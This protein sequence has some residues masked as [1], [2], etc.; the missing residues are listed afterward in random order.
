MGG[1]VSVAVGSIG[2]VCWWFDRECEHDC[3]WDL[4]EYT[5]AAIVCFNIYLCLSENSAFAW[6]SARGRS[7]ATEKALVTESFCLLMTVNSKRSLEQ[8][9][10]SGL[11]VCRCSRAKCYKAISGGTEVCLLWLV[12]IADRS[13]YADSA[14]LSFASLAWAECHS[15]AVQTCLDSPRQYWNCWVMFE[16]LSQLLHSLKTVHSKEIKESWKWE[17][18]ALLQNSILLNELLQ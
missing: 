15:S 17:I 5:A 3:I 13:P 16:Y 11:T 4:P 7:C 10:P 1:L 18:R 8:L 12:P 9:P 6:G 14:F 2:L